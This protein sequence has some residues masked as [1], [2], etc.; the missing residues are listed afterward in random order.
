MSDVIYI[1]L[2]ISPLNMWEGLFG[3]DMVNFLKFNYSESVNFLLNIFIL[4]SN[5]FL[6]F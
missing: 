2:N 1:F 3:I 6:L 5:Y 4:A